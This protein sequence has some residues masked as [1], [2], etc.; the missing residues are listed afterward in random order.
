M[1]RTQS[2]QELHGG[3]QQVYEFKNGFGASVIRHE[4]SYGF[5]QGLWELAVLDSAGEITYDTPITMD[6]I[7]HLTRTEIQSYLKEISKL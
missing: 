4:G 7:G 3:I 6:V 1:Y 5:K 2:T